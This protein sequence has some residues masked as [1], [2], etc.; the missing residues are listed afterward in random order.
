MQQDSEAERD[1]V[2]Q[3]TER[4]WLVSS[5]KDAAGPVAHPDIDQPNRQQHWR[6]DCALPVVAAGM[7][8]LKP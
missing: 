7:E 5:A 6:E 4:R 8:W 2:N 1:G 3:P